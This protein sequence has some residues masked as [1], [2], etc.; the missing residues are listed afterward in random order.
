MPIKYEETEKVRRILMTLYGNPVAQGR[1]RFSRQGGFVK[2]YDPIK[3]KAYKALIRLELQPLLAKPGFRQFKN[4]CRVHL[5][6]CRA[7]PSGFSQ[8]K[9]KE[10]I[11]AKIRPTTRPDTDNYI[12]GILDALNGTVLKDDS[13]VCEINAGKIYSD[14]PRLEVMVEERLRY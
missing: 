10:A 1:P 12:K 2:T 3:S 5:L 9:R 7:I 4:P 14:K 13:I 8:K 6:I 11:E